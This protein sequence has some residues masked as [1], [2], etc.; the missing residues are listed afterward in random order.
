MPLPGAGD[1]AMRWWRTDENHHGSGALLTSYVGTMILTTIV[2][3]TLVVSPGMSASASVAIAFLFSVVAFAIFQGMS[4]RWSAEIDLVARKVRISRR[5]FG[6]WVKTTVDC[7]FD[8]CS[9]VGTFEYDT[10]GHLSYS[11]YVKLNDG[12]RHAIPMVGSTLTEAT[13]VA[14]Q[15]AAATG[16]PRLDIY[17]G[18]IY[19]RPDDDTKR[20]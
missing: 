16:I 17:V 12:T 5:S 3:I 7:P 2:I 19:I 18:P 15:L 20:G 11:V 6:R 10:D 14:S 4:R 13:R 8:E 9:A 1:G